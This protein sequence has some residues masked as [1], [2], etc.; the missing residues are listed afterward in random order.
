M[1]PEAPARSDLANLSW[2]HG[3]RGTPVRNGTRHVA[4][5][6]PA[7]KHD[8]VRTTVSSVTVRDRLESARRDMRDELVGQPDLM[9]LDIMRE[10]FWPAPDFVAQ[11][12]APFDI[13]VSV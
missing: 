2:T 10:P 8:L 12:R 3:T 11:F 13:I 1:I 4:T 6:N 5:P 7:K 9:H